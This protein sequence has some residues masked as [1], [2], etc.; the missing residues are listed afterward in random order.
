MIDILTGGLLAFGIF[1]ILLTIIASAS[2]LI[3]YGLT[4]SVFTRLPIKKEL[5]TR[6][7]PGFRLY[8]TICWVQFLAMNYLS[9]PRAVCPISVYL[10]DNLFSRT[11]QRFSRFRCSQ[12]LL[13]FCCAWPI[14]RFSVNTG[15]LMPLPMD[16]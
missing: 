5:P 12:S 8:A 7:L 10:A 2:W 4:S 1:G 11:V 6:F 9:H 16:F 14:F 3:A 15:K 13:L